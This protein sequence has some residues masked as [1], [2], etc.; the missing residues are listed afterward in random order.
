MIHQTCN[1]DGEG[2]QS[3][4]LGTDFEVD[5]LDG[6]ESLERRKVERVDSTEDEDESKNGIAGGIVAVDGIGVLDASGNQRR[7]ECACCGGH[8][9]PHDRA[10]E[11]TAE[12]HLAA[13]DLL[14]ELSS[15]DS[16]EELEAGVAQVDISLADGGIDANG[17]ED[18]GHEV[19]KDGV[20]TP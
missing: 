12:H 3:H 10:T 6:I 11:E 16:P 8:A 4:T 9:H 18:G 15:D 14:N 1:R 17:I 20:S 2:L 7:G 13:T 19:G 5:T